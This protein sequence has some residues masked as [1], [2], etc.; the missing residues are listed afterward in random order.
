MPDLEFKALNDNEI[1]IEKIL[2][3]YENDTSLKLSNKF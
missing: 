2:N 1:L 3:L